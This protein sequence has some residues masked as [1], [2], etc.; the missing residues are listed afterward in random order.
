MGADEAGTL[1]K[2]ESLRTNLIETK[3]AELAR[4]AASR[5]LRATDRLT[6]RFSVEC[7][8]KA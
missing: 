3:I 1:A 6:T 8:P 5:A 7:D 4:V 2:L